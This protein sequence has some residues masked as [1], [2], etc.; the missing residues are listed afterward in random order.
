[1]CG[2]DVFSVQCSELCV[3]CMSVKCVCRTQATLM[4][5][6]QGQTQPLSRRR[7]INKLIFMASLRVVQGWGLKSKID[8]QV[9]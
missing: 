9:P 2:C 7:V 4:T 6:Q 1:M 8:A 5:R 3:E